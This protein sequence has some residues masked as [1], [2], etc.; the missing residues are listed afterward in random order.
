MQHPRFRPHIRTCLATMGLA[1][2]AQAHAVVE[3][4]HWQART[5]S[6][7]SG[8]FSVAVHQTT[9]GDLTGVLLAYN[10]G[11]LSGFLGAATDNVDFFVVKP[12]A[13]LSNAT[14]S[15]GQEPFLGGPSGATGKLTLSTPT[16][17]RDFYLG[18]RTRSPKDPG[19]ADAVAAGQLSSFFTGFGWAHF[20]VDA[21]GAPNLVGSAMAFREGGIVVGTLQA[22]PEPSTWALMGLGFAGLAW[23]ARSHAKPAA[24]QG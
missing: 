16:V 15:S 8:N 7:S 21:F 24:H 17:G 11:A 5:I 2:S 22:V 23:R 10:S 14:L 20:Q 1:L 18:V 6:G 4:G 9:G 3:A 12:G 19:Y 13:V